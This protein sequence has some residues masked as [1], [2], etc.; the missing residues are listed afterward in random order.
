MSTD[1]P[2]QQQDPPPT[3]DDVLALLQ[4]ISTR[5]VRIETRL[6]RLLLTQGVPLG[7]EGR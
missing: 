1:T 2:T 4:E 7:P 5:V 6:S 3:V